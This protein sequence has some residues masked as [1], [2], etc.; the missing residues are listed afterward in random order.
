MRMT[1]R[2]RNRRACFP[3]REASWKSHGKPGEEHAFLELPNEPPPMTGLFLKRYRKRRAP[4]HDFLIQLL[5]KDHVGYALPLFLGYGHAGD[6]H[7]YAF[8]RLADPLLHSVALGRGV[9]HD[10]VFTE[11]FFLS[12]VTASMK[13][14]SFI[15]AHGYYYPD[16]AFENILVRFPRNGVTLIDVDSCLPFSVA[17]GPTDC[18]Q[19]WWTLFAEYRFTDRRFLPPTMVMSMVVI[20]CRALAEL[21]RRADYHGANVADILRARPREQ[22]EVFQVFH[23]QNVETFVGLFRSAPGDRRRIPAL[24]RAWRSL[25][26]SMRDDLPVSWSGISR[27]ITDLFSLTDP[28]PA[29]LRIDFGSDHGLYALED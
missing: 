9:R 7:Y 20:L 14:F 2:F 28:K 27:F 4:A 29:G 24:M 21:G 6:W 17:A 10:L 16:Y 22:R 5:D 13:A 25:L 19:T 11:A 8:Q 18:R 15:N 23:E 12:L 3:L 26:D 1:V